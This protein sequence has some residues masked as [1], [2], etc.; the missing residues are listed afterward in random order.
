MEK[1]MV[2]LLGSKFDLYQDINNINETN[3]NFKNEFSS[4]FNT[5]TIK[6]RVNRFA[7]SDLNY[8]LRY[9]HPT[10]IT[11]GIFEKQGENLH[12]A[13]LPMTVPISLSNF[14]QPIVI[15]T[16]SE[17]KVY[18]PSS[19]PHHDATWSNNEYISNSENSEETAYQYN[20]YTAYFYVDV[21]FKNANTNQPVYIFY[22]IQNFPHYLV[23][24]KVEVINY[25][26]V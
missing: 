7:R 10:N 21:T 5:D 22:M 12:H 9:N 23:I 4:Y 6:L 13:V 17:V 8:T 16:V 14:L 3:T 15:D 19:K 2:K 11:S 26:T 25:I 1:K 18:Y 20:S 24:R